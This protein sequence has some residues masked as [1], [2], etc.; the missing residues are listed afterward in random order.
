MKKLAISIF[1]FSIAILIISCST[2]QSDDSPSGSKKISD[3]QGIPVYLNGG[4]Q[5][6]WN[7]VKAHLDS[8]YDSLDSQTK[9]KL[10]NNIDRIFIKASGGFEG[11]AGGTLSIPGDANPS[12]LYDYLFD[13]GFFA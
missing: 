1:M 10:K 7:T 6:N 3:W 8:I 13:N 2:E 12:Y 4:T 11:S 9:T 5:D